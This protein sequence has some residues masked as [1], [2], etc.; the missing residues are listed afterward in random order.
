MS[1]LVTNEL[2]SPNGSPITIPFGHTL[3]YSGAIIQT[4]A[5]KSRDRTTFSSLT[6][7]NGT[8]VLPLRVPITPKYSTSTIYL[9]WMVNGEFHHDNVFTIFQNGALVTTAGSEG[10]NSVSGNVRWSGYA[11]AQYDGDEASTPSNMYIQ[12]SA[13]A[14]STS[15]RTY[16]PAVRSGGGTAYTFYLNRSISTIGDTYETQ[17]SIG[18]AMEIAA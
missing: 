8:E 13:P 2:Y 7:G 5:I 14:G 6:T 1:R 17:M 12:Y 4:V 16:A 15:A 9:Q 11:V 18:L 10:Y 3:L